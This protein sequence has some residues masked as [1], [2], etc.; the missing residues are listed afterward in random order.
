MCYNVNKISSILYYKGGFTMK[1]LILMVVTGVIL[2]GFAVTANA[3]MA[4]SDLHGSSI[5]PSGYAV[6]SIHNPA[7]PL[8]VASSDRIYLDSNRLWAVNS[9]H[10]FTIS[11]EAMT[12][13]SMAKPER[14][15][16][17]DSLS[18][19]CARSY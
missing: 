14:L 5:D 17:F 9:F 18:R 13:G 19:F 10:S 7:S 16:C 15:Y 3:W 8:S 6:V 1:K 4:G 2:A 12:A 11:S